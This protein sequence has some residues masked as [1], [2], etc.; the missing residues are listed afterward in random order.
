MSEAKQLTKH[1]AAKEAPLQFSSKSSANEG[2]E[3]CEVSSCGAI[4]KELTFVR[5]AQEVG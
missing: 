5:M 3:R 4:G 2:N 1:G